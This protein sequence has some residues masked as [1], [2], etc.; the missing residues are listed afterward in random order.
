LTTA[1]GDQFGSLHRLPATGAVTQNHPLVQP[2]T[3][4]SSRRPGSGWSLRGGTARGADGAY[5]GHRFLPCSG[6]NQQ[7]PLGPCRG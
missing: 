6:S 2:S 5:V 7:R 4:P 3:S 1:S